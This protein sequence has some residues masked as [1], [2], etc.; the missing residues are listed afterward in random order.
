MG[1]ST[2]P[3]WIKT[4]K[5]YIDYIL[6]KYIRSID[7]ITTVS[8][9]IAEQYARDYAIKRPDIITN[10]PKYS[11]ILPVFHDDNNT[12]RMVHHG[13]AAR[14]R[15][16]GEMI[17]IVQCLDRRFTLDLYLVKKDEDYYQELLDACNSSGRVRL[18]EPIKMHELVPKLNEY[19]V[20]LYVL[21]PTSF[22]HLHALPNKI[23]EFVQARLAIAIGPS[24]EMA[25]I[26]EEYGPWSCRKG[27]YC[28]SNGRSAGGNRQCPTKKV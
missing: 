18:L 6:N 4:Q 13:I 22:N 26:V 21:P 2:D 5:P 14:Q 8:E 9:G 16:I 3:E 1:Q 20:G 15:D 27:F 17:K 23:F 12:V 28:R 24:P 7:A 11:H 10:A 19:D 25:R